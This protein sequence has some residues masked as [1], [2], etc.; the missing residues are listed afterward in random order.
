MPIKNNDYS[1]LR[2]M[3]VGLALKSQTNLFCDEDI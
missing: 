1:K 2:G 3:I